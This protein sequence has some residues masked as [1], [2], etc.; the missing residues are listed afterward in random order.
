MNGADVSGLV[1]FV[2]WAALA[3][4][5]AA[6]VLLVVAHRRIEGLE[7]AHTARKWDIVALRA[8]LGAL[9]RRMGLPAPDDDPAHGSVDTTPEGPVS[10]T[11]DAP[12]GARHLAGPTAWR[13]AHRPRKDRPGRP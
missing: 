13:R 4:W 10:R 7:R 1:T 6:G 11:A 2:A 12:A 9:R 8:E 3:G 5:I